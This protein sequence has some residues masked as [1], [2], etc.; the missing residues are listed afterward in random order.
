M[1]DRLLEP[2]PVPLFIVSEREWLVTTLQRVFGMVPSLLVDL[3]D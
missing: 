3:F 2:E 1:T